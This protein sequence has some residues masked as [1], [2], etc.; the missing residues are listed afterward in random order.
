[1]S[2]NVKPFETERGFRGYEFIDRYGN[3]CSIQDSSIA[4]ED[5]IWFGINDPKPQIMVSQARQFG[6]DPKGETTGWVPYP[7]PDE[8]SIWTRMHLTRDQVRD[9]MPVLQYFA[10]HGMLPVPDEGEDNE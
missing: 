6:V 4:T 9:L 7:I 3:E 8:V 1:M 2:E 5:C 10:D